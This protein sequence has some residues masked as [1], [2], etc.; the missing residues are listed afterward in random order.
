[1]TRYQCRECKT[2]HG[3]DNMVAYCAACYSKVQLNLSALTQPTGDGDLEQALDNADHVAA[4][5][6]I[7]GSNNLLVTLAKAYRAERARQNK[8]YDA[9]YER[10]RHEHYRAEAAEKERDEA[11]ARLIEHIEMARQSAEVL[12][13]E[14]D[15]SQS[16]LK[17]ANGLLDEARAKLL[18]FRHTHEASYETV[19][20]GDE[21][22]E[23]CLTDKC[24]KCGLSIRD[25]IHAALQ[26]K[27]NG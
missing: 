12:I 11:R 20:G 21:P 25:E 24:G 4:M 18:L 16:R 2:E 1:M 8:A 5:P 6:L 7:P 10:W 17:T 26:D 27:A 9:V 15:E 22:V 13:R 23:E 14:R 3:T 19:G